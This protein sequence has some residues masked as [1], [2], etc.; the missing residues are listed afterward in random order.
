MTKILRALQ[1]MACITGL[2]SL[3][4]TAFAQAFDA[5]RLYGA[6]SGKDGGLV[7]AVVIAGK[8]YQGSAARRTMALPLLD[9]QWANGW[10]AGTANGFGY[11]F[12][13][14]P[15]IQYG[16][17]LTADF[18]RDE[19]RS[20][21]LAGLGDVDAAAEFGGFFNFAVTRDWF[22]TSSLRY[23]SGNDHKGLLVDLGAGTAFAIAPNWRLAWGLAATLANAESM[24]SYFGIT[25][26]QALASGYGSYTPGAGLRDVRTNLSVTHQ[27]N[28]RMS[29][30]AGLSASALMG[31]AKD[32][33]LVRKT[34]AVNGVVAVAYSF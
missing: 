30:T 21:A 7:G 17:R 31:D 22:L 6:A 14:P 4:P 10:F 5:V 29:I 9:Y 28:P 34:T 18:G 2:A 24:Q 19:S 20:A 8:Q 12:A 33:P 3:A 11:K 27:F 1:T 15:R 26:A 16:L 13:S 25:A 32:S 23:G